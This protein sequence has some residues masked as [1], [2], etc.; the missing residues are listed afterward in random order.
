ML[1][2]CSSAVL[3]SSR[4]LKRTRVW[5]PVGIRGKEPRQR[6]RGF[7][8]SGHQ[9]MVAR[10]GEPQGSPASASRVPRSSNPVPGCHPCLE[11]W[12]AVVERLEPTEANMARTPKRS[13]GARVIPFPA[14]QA[15]ANPA[16]SK[17]LRQWFIDH[18]LAEKVPISALTIVVSAGGDIDT[19]GMGIEPEMCPFLIDALASAITMLE[20]QVR[21]A[22]VRPY[23]VV[24]LQHGGRHHG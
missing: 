15:A 10:A 19:T 7:F 3:D 16:R 22:A 2:S 23:S 1:A 9:S 24:R 14:Q 21:Q 18:A 8:S 4:P 12:K 5:K 13:A 17:A 20:D 6:D 11:A